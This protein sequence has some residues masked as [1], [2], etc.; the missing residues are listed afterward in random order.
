M[1]NKTELTQES[2]G[3]P[4]K[5]ALD[6]MHQLLVFSSTLLVLVDGFR[7]LVVQVLVVEVDLPLGPGQGSLVPSVLGPDGT[8]MAFL[9][10]CCVFFFRRSQ[11]GW[12]LLV[13]I[14][15]VQV[16]VVAEQGR[17]WQIAFTAEPETNVG[18][19]KEERAPYS[20]LLSCI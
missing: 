11:L 2:L 7:V 5:H 14:V 17:W 6:G 1:Q 4:W 18:V 8:E 15:F 20:A 10:F 13:L 19:Y 9:G 16:A 12:R 3:V